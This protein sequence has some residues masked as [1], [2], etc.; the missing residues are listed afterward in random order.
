MS[1]KNQSPADPA[2]LFDLEF[3]VDSTQSA[4]PQGLII[5]VSGTSA[6]SRP[7]L[8]S[9]GRDCSQ[10]QQYLAVNRFIT[11]IEQNRLRA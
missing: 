4:R 10:L 6:F 5:G 2:D 1:A 8:L 11:S 7:P 3:G 9:V